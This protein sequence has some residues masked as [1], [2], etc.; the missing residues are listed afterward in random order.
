MTYLAQPARLWCEEKKLFC[1][2]IR[3]CEPAGEVVLWSIFILSN[4][5]LLLLPLFIVFIVI[6]D[7]RAYWTKQIANGFDSV[8]EAA[9]RRRVDDAN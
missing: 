8:E 4:G 9:D 6:R 3:Y 5:I 1:D 7:Q 2:G